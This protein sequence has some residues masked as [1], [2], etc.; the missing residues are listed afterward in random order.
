MLLLVLFFF[1]CPLTVNAETIET[2]YLFVKEVDAS[3]QVGESE[4]LHRESN[5]LLE[6]EKS[7]TTQAFYKKGTHL[8]DYPLLT[9]EFC[10][11]DFSPWQEKRK[12]DPTL[13]EQQKTVFTY[14]PLKKVRR[15]YLEK[16]EK[17]T[18]LEIR[19]TSHDQLLYQEQ[20]KIGEAIT[21]DL[22]K[23]YDV[24]TLKITLKCYLLQEDTKGHVTITTDD[25]SYLHETV[26]VTRKGI[27][28]VEKKLINCLQKLVFAKTMETTTSNIEEDPYLKI[29]QK[30]T[31]Y[32]YREKK[33]RY[34]KEKKIK[35]SNNKE[36]AGFRFIGIKN[37]YYLYRK[38][39]ITLKEGIVLKDYVDLDKIIVSTSFPLK[40]L[41]IKSRF[42]GNKAILT[43]SYKDFSIEKTVVNQPNQYEKSRVSTYYEPSL[44][45]ILLSHLL[46]LSIEI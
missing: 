10:Y 42:Y 2:P 45:R 36:E 39:Q 32:R 21:I 27:S 5:Y 8:K 13:E 26:T 34:Q 37:H 38:E 35:E 7:E 46:K 1:L 14:Q 18:L 3:Y 25:K 17:L 40:D 30:K 22:K 33:Y 23:D 12:E 31:W 43:F 20:P 6:E 11:T 19:I 4:Q 24:A 28:I 9:E 41:L 44:S 15:L 16:I 29:I